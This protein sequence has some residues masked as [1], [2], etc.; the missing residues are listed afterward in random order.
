[1]SAPPRLLASG[2]A[3]EAKLLRAAKSERP[4]RDG[5]QRAVAAASAAAIGSC[6]VG[7]A[8][9]GLLAAIKGPGWL[10]ALGAGITGLVVMAGSTA[11]LKPTAPPPTAIATPA[12]VAPA[13]RSSA[14]PVVAVVPPVPAT[15][16]EERT[17]PP[18]GKP[19]RKGAIA[20]ATAA[21][22]PLPVEDELTLLRRAKSRL[23][24]S[25]AAGA[26][27]ALDAHATTYPRSKLAEEAAALRV[28]ALVATG[29]G[30][31]AQRAADVFLERHPESP[32]AE[33]VRSAVRRLG[34]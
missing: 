27:E 5:M 11:G 34:R 30:V 18:A 2:S 20:P 22:P 29:D 12:R 7:T 32:Y 23:A 26:L 31:R 4:S 6:A 28:E 15:A 10:L 16:K 8:K 33:R 17:P 13:A 3:F 25:D 1:M 19:A 14:E 24:G 21:A 9:T